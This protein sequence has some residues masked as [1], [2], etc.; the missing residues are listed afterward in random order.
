MF[1][2]K[3]KENIITVLHIVIFIDLVSLTVFTW[4]NNCFVNLFFFFP[5]NVDSHINECHCYKRCCSRYYSYCII[6]MYLK[7]KW[8]LN[9]KTRA[10]WCLLLL[11]QWFF[12]RNALLNACPPV[13]PSRACRPVSHLIMFDDVFPQLEA[14]TTWSLGLWALSLEVLWDCV[15]IWVPRSPGPCTSSVP[16]RSSWWGLCVQ[17]KV[18]LGPEN[19]E[20][21]DCRNW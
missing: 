1:L 14:L 12:S 17:L 5:D 18:R 16:S 6:D 20:S 10:A 4:T 19:P 11:Y 8:H 9:L 13:Y 2:E 7:M 21:G 3:E 15:S